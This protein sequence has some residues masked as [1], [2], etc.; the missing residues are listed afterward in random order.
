LR[1]LKV[2]N[3]E[4]YVDQE[5]NLLDYTLWTKDFTESVA[6]DNKIVLSDIHWRIID[7]VRRYYEV[8]KVMPPKKQIEKEFKLNEKD[9]SELFPMK[10][11]DGYLYL[12]SKLAG[13]PVP[14]G[15]I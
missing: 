14:S 13:L 15:D 7:Y 12:L 2:K 3:K 11:K 10:Y 9:M 5:G 6:D 1:I 8:D 4:F